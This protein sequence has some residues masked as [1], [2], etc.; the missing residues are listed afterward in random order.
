[1]FL[2]RQNILHY[3]FSLFRF[4]LYPF[5]L[6]YGAIVWIRNRFYDA[7]LASSIKFD[8]PVVSVGNLSVGGTGKTPHI[9]YL[10]RLLQ[11]QYRVATLSRGYKRYTRGFLLADENAD[12]RKIGD[13]PMQY[14]LKFPDLTVCVAEDR[15]TGI[16]QLLLNR[17]EVEVVLL[18]DAYQHRS[19]KPGLNIL[20]TD[21]SMPFY[22]DHILPFGRLRENRGAY[23]RADLI[24]VSKCPPDMD[25][26]TAV[27][28]Q[29]NIKP[30]LRQEIFFTSIQYG[31][32]YDFF[33][34]EHVK[35]KTSNAI[36]VC[37]I[38]NP[39]PL[40]SYLKDNTAGLHL[41]TYP[42]HHYFSDSDTE[43][44]KAAHDNWKAGDKI[45]ITTEKDAARLHLHTDTIK[46][47]NIPVIVLPI[48]VVVLFNKEVEFNRLVLDYIEKTVLEN[49]EPEQ[50][51][52]GR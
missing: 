9:E 36:L 12:A 8:I 14:H 44:I 11:Y 26:A 40:V 13:E 15:L 37:C 23:Q 48:A 27:E 29:R 24:I 45:I 22:K 2:G 5:A 31:T 43:E 50:N 39:A 6:L 3:I 20:I 16:P 35:I 38:A 21:F 4:L 1:M 41:L 34:H 52:E 30:N 28:I 7:G 33:T 17:S 10:V 49:T 19:V 25:A 47:W 46:A 32:P 51:V 42:D 18:D